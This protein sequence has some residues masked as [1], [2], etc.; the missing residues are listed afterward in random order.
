MYVRSGGCYPIGDAAAD[1]GSIGPIPSTGAFSIFG[2]KYNFAPT[3]TPGVIGWELTND[4]VVASIAAMHA[5]FV[6]TMVKA[7]LDARKCACPQ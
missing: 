3:G 7:Y 2:A 6:A 1:I 4:S 5:G